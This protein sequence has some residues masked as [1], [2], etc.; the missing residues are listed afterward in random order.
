VSTVSGMDAVSSQVEVPL[1]LA[2]KIG[3]QAGHYGFGDAENLVP[4]A[5]TL[6]PADRTAAAPTAGTGG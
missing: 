4:P 6:T 1:A 2:A 3:G 5:V